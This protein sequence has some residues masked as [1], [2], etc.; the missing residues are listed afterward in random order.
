[1]NLILSSLIFSSYLFF[2]SLLFP[3]F[4]SL[5]SFLECRPT[6]DLLVSKGYSVEILRSPWTCFDATLYHALLIVDPEEGFGTK[7]VEKLAFDI[8]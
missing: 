7:E 5:L 2:F 1:M 3:F 8:R 6:Y 4:P